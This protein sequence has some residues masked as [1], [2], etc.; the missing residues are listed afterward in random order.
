MSCGGFTPHITSSRKLREGFTFVEL[1]VVIAVTTVLAAVG[2]VSVG[3]YYGRKMIVS[4]IDEVESVLNATRR[5]SLSQE[6]GGRWGIQFSKATTGVSS[7]YTFRGHTFAS[8]T[9]DQ[10]YK[11]PVS[12]SFSNPFASSSY[13]TVFS[14]LTGAP[15]EQK[16]FSMT[17][18]RVSMIVGD[19]IVKLTGTTVSRI[20]TGLLGYWHLDESS[21]TVAYDASGKGKHG[22]VSGNPVRQSGSECKAGT[23]INFDGTDDK[24]VFSNISHQQFTKTA[25]IKPNLSSCTGSAE[26][27]CTIIGPY[28]EISSPASLT[29][30][31]YALVPQ[32]WYTA[33]GA[34]ASNV[35]QHVA[36]TFDGN[37]LRLYVNGVQKHAAS[38]TLNGAPYSSSLGQYG[39][40]NR[41]MYG[42][43]DEVRLY[44]RALS[45]DE[46]LTQYNDLK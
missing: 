40:N 26:G 24:V 22:T 46:I 5:R 19:V 6:E 2:F 36:V 20:E 15:S 32:G 35:W 25:W 28:F 42:P 3:N 17:S 33:S 27:R 39:A 13:E 45:A 10:R 34:L 30:Y 16:V 23:C 1:M 18:G 38:S 11:L 43:V 31:S 29:F 12:V 4:A 7:Y 9:A 37:S 21:S 44:D 41:V 8:G 14:P